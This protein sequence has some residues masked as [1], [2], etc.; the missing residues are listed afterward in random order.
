M[1]VRED[2]HPH[3][4]KWQPCRQLQKRCQKTEQEKGWDYPLRSWQQL[5]LNKYF[6]KLF[7]N[8]VII[9][10]SSDHNFKSKI[11]VLEILNDIKV[12]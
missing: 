7:Q 9:V 12:L 3:C 11:V 4:T 8:K 6:V 1:L 5:L 2:K 10:S